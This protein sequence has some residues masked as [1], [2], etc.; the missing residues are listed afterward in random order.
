MTKILWETRDYIGMPGKRPIKKGTPEDPRDSPRQVKD[1]ESVLR[2]KLQEK[3][4]ELRQL[5]KREKALGHHLRVTRT[6]ELY[7]ASSETTTAAAR[8][9]RTEIG[10]LREESIGLRQQLS[11]ALE[12]ESFWQEKATQPFNDGQYYGD[13]Q[14]RRRVHS[15]VTS[16]L[17][18]LQCLVHVALPKS[19][20]LLPP[21]DKCRTSQQVIASRLLHSEARIDAMFQRYVRG[22]VCEDQMLGAV[23]DSMSVP[24]SPG[25]QGFGDTQQGYDFGHP[26]WNHIAS[27][28][29]M[30][31]TGR[32]APATSTVR[33]EFVRHVYDDL[34]GGDAEQMFSQP[35]SSA[36]MGHSQHSRDPY[37]IKTRSGRATPE[38][39]AFIKSLDARGVMDTSH[40]PQNLKLTKDSPRMDERNA[41]LQSKGG[42]YPRSSNR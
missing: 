10:G 5:K 27:P 12:Q 39:Q 36:G 26:A 8:A 30:Q 25:E 21:P 22:A 4:Q 31:D 38:A 6:G 34:L 42:G 37:A 2:Q 29:R 7:L 33:P 14:E 23:Q 18:V 28:R 19:N 1:D 24:K 17:R 11:E 40:N 16:A 9:L 13:P 20:E 41:R 15:A 32:I 35:M 3:F